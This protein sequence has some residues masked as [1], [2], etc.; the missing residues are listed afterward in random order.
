VGKVQNAS[1]LTLVVEDDLL[2]QDLVSGA[3]QEGG[4][5]AAVVASGEEAITLLKEDPAKYRALLTD[6]HLKGKL[7]GW[8][9]AKTSR[10]LN[11]EMPVVYMTGAAANEW[12][13]HGVPNSILLNKPFAPAQVVTAISN[14]LNQMPPSQE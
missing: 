1:L 4:F 6:I 5:E 2:I 10:E 9:V 3:L 14:L 8:D 12:P 7:T 13:S 11:P